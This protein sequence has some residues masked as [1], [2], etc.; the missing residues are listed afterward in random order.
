MVYHCFQTR[1]DNTTLSHLP[2]RSTMWPPTYDVTT[3]FGNYYLYISVNNF[4]KFIIDVYTYDITYIHIFF[5]NLVK[6]LPKFVLSVVVVNGTIYTK[7]KYCIILQCL[8]FKTCRCREKV[9]F[10][11][12]TVTALIDCVPFGI[13]SDKYLWVIASAQT[14]A[15]HFLFANFNTSN[16]ILL[17]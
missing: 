3:F 7:Y 13:L 1:N 15:K 12:K 11:S 2:Q 4:F 8:E 5:F 14:K 9:W 16:A 10:W 6:L 17:L